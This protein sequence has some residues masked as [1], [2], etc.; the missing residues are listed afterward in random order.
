MYTVC[1]PNLFINV[2]SIKCVQVHFVYISSFL[3]IF[4]GSCGWFNFF[5]R[6][7]S[8]YLLLYCFPNAPIPRQTT[9]TLVSN[10]KSKLFEL[11]CGF[12]LNYL[13]ILSV[14]IVFRRVSTVNSWPRKTTITLVS[15]PKSKLF[16]LYCGFN[17]NYIDILS[18]CIVFRRVSTVNS[19]PR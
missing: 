14:C 10:P 2:S 8:L 19:W 13:D 9:I 11:Y 5:L 7:P 16:E 12:N 1:D 17:L 6:N 3:I 15:N 4:L 18:V